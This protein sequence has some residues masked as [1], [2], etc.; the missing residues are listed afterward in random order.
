MLHPRRVIVGALWALALMPLP[1][2]VF[3][4]AS[5]PCDIA[6]CM[7]S[8][9]IGSGWQAGGVVANDPYANAQIFRA[10]RSGALTEI[11]LGVWSQGPHPAVLEIRTVANGAPTT[12]VLASAPIPGAP[13]SDSAPHVV[14]F[15]SQNL[16]LNAGATYA[17]MVRPTGPTV[18]VVLARFPQCPLSSGSVAFMHTF[19]SGASWQVFNDR[20]YAY[21]ICADAIVGTTPGTW[22]AIKS[23]YR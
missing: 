4:Q 10:T 5:G 15:R 8:P 22:G 19:D 3:A 13:Y 9:W 11:A 14:N 12:T 7:P 20:S 1:A 2:A 21:R 18:V 17:L 23:L 6:A 16:L